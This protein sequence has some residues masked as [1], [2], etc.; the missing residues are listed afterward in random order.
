ML[1][2]LRKA[3]TAF[4]FTQF[5]GTVGDLVADEP[6]EL[7]RHSS[8]D[9]VTIPPELPIQR[10]IIMDDNITQPLLDD[11][12]GTPLH[13]PDAHVQHLVSLIRAN[14]DKVHWHNGRVRA[15]QQKIE[16]HMELVETSTRDAEMALD[17]SYDNFVR[18]VDLTPGG[19]H[20]KSLEDS[21]DPAALDT[22]TSNKAIQTEE[23]HG[24]TNTAPA[25]GQSILFK[26]SLFQTFSRTGPLHP[27]ACSETPAVSSISRAALPSL[28]EPQAHPKTKNARSA[29]PLSMEPPRIT[30]KGKEK[31]RQQPQQAYL[32]L[33]GHGD[34]IYLNRTQANKVAKAQGCMT[35]TFLS[36]HDAQLAL[37]SCIASKLLEYL[38]EVE[39]E[40]TWFA[41]LKGTNPGVCQRSE[42]LRQIG[43]EHLKDLTSDDILL[44]ST[45]QEAED[46][47]YDCKQM[48]E[49]E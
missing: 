42:L 14:L 22:R 20:V 18:G 41:V 21:A 2:A 40:S 30:A 7:S 23:Y 47:Y 34:S 49:S 27:F 1:R 25:K 45:E 39:Y 4:L 5:P 29:L 24:T 26:G 11:V 32:V 33:T 43:K 38:R 17:H 19:G 15:H 13:I 6:L 8:S 3:T 46:I 10:V 28:P 16:Q 31:E 48:Y 35:L 37:T 12:S 44:A 9:T 36:Q